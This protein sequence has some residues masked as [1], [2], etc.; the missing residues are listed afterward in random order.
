MK[1]VKVGYL[2]L[3][4]LASQVQTSDAAMSTMEELGEILE[5]TV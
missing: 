5:M 2:T 3:L 4:A 1:A